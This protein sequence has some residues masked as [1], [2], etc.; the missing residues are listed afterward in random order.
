VQAVAPAIRQTGG[1]HARMRRPRD[2]LG[3][4]G[5][6]VAAA[7]TDGDVDLPQDLLV[8]L[9]RVRHLGLHVLLDGVGHLQQQP[10]G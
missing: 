7:R 2:S 8:A 4:V 3:A 10:V 9:H 6:G 5:A 1:M